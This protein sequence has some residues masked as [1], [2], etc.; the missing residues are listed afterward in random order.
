MATKKKQA[1]TARLEIIC[2]DNQEAKVK[3]NGNPQDLTA[4]IA[5]LL[6]DESEDNSLRYIFHTAISVI[7]FMDQR[8]KKKPAKKNIA[9]KKKK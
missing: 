8:E 3:I 1:E 2:L 9:P 5:S 4:A 6:T 7:L